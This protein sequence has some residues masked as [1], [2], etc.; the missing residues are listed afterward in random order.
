MIAPSAH[1][2]GYDT[3]FGSFAQFCVAQEHQVLPK[4]P[5]LTWEQAAAPTLVG[6]TAYRM[7]FG[8]QGNVLHEGD[9]VLIWGGSGGLGSQ[10]IQ[11]AKWGGGHP[12]R[13][14]LQSRGSGLLH[15][16]G[17]QRLHRSARVLPLGHPAAL[18]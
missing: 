10:A 18:G 17:R 1:I 2:W 8:W 15:A 7:L 6:T 4:T 12:N 9:V 3:N 14:R 13:R 16:L 5:D 11:L